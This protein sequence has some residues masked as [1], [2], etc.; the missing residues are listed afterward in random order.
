MRKVCC[1]SMIVAGVACGPKDT[2]ECRT[3]RADADKAMA[4]ADALQAELDAA[5]K[6]PPVIGSA[7]C[8]VEGLNPRQHMVVPAKGGAG[9]VP[10]AEWLRSTAMRAED[11]KIMPAIDR[12]PAIADFR[13]AEKA[14]STGHQLLFIEGERKKPKLLDAKTYEKGELSGRV[15]LWSHEQRR[16]VC[17]ADAKAE[18]GEALHTIKG[19][20]GSGERSLNSQLTFLT[21]AAGVEVLK[22][23]K[24]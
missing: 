9:K 12:E 1:V 11:C 16:I 18:S 22:K 3:Y 17:A 4:A 7:P 23:V 20:P 5:M 21:V 15:L 13:D 14:L 6:E 2:E 10:A 8:E 24:K 19:R